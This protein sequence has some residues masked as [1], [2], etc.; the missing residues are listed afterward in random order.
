MPTGWEAPSDGADGGYPGPKIPFV[1]EVDN[2]VL[3]VVLL[4]RD[5]EVKDPE[6]LLRE[7]DDEESVV[8]DEVELVLEDEDAIEELDAEELVVDDAFEDIELVETTMSDCEELA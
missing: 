4:D 8:L 3:D 5:V 7:S 1:E 2:A 6:V